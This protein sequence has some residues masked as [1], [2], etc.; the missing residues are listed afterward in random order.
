MKRGGVLSFLLH[1][2]VLTWIFFVPIGRV[3]PLPAALAVDLVSP[4]PPSEPEPPPA[5]PEPPPPAPPVHPHKLAS[6][7]V[8][9]VPALPDEAIPSIGASESPAASVAVPGPPPAAVSMAD[10][11]GK[12][13]AMARYAAIL[14]ARISGNKPRF[15]RFSGTT[16]VTFALDAAGEVLW[17]RI[18]ASSGNQALDETALDTVRRSQPFPVPPPGLAPDTLIFT[19]PFTFRRSGG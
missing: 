17:V 18:E 1:A 5:A 11:G 7:P 9:T 19:L 2:A 4:P 10:G 15:V 14:W 13:Q 16:P 8:A 6:K 3:E 12:D